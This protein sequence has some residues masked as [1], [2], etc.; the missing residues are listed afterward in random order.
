MRSGGKQ[1]TDLRAIEVVENTYLGMASACKTGENELRVYSQIKRTHAR[2]YLCEC[3]S[4]CARFDIKFIYICVCVCLC[5]LYAC[6]S[7]NVFTL[8]KLTATGSLLA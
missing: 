5:I 2:M 4:K 7:V 8:H 6:V 1:V 3:V